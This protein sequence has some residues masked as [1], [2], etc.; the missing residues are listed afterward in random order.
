MARTIDPPGFTSGRIKWKDVVTSGPHVTRVM[1][2]SPAIHDVTFVYPVEKSVIQQRSVENSPAVL[3]IAVSPLEF[4]RAGYRRPIDVEGRYF[5][6]QTVGTQAEQA[7]SAARIKE[8]AVVEHVLLKQV[9]HRI[10]SDAD[11]IISQSG[12][13]SGPILSELEWRVVRDTIG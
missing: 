4:L 13:K 10:L 11:S 6:P 7:T 8:R 2:D 3:I 12:Q 5:C 9:S 1:C